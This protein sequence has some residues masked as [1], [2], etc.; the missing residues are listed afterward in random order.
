MAWCPSSASPTCHLPGFYRPWWMAYPI[1]SPRTQDLCWRGFRTRSSASGAPVGRSARRKHLPR[2]LGLP[3]GWPHLTFGN[4]PGAQ[5]RHWKLDAIES[6]AGPDRP[7]AWVD[8]AFD[9]GCD[10]WAAERKAP[11]LLVR[12]DPATG[13]RAEHVSVLE[14]WARRL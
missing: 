13:L 3:G 11:T 9:A 10:A 7:L 12:T 5:P 6:H 1:C 14:R 4:G 8:D 2:L